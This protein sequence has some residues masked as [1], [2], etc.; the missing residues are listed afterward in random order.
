MP[1][2][3]HTLRLGTRGSLLARTQSQ[4]VADALV[5]RHP[6]LRVELVVCRTTGDR[7]TDRPLHGA[8][9]KG[10]FVKELEEALLRGE[11][12][13]AV[14]SS[15]DV[16]VTMPLVDQSD[17]LLAAFP[18]REDPRDV[19][20]CRTTK[21]I[22]GLPAHAKVGT[23]SLRRKAQLLSLRP[24][25]R[26]EL[27]RGNIDTR[28]NKC[29]K[30]SEYDA[31]IL[32]MSGLKRA[33]LFDE[34]T[35]TPLSVDEMVPA[36]GQGAL[37]LQCRRSDGTTQL[38]LSSLHDAATATCVGLERSLVTA[39]EGDC[40]SPIGALATVAG[41]SVTLRAAVAAVGGLPPLV[42]A[43]AR[44]DAPAAA[45]ADVLDQLNRQNVRPLLHPAARPA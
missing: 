20:V 9:G 27:L 7:I 34:R 3:A 26:V 21:G 28:V 42:M 11:V 43:S 39:L 38:L 37:A 44:G 25:L 5:A 19:L 15:K 22:A 17:L 16:P 32:A 36:A 1:T 41:G 10:L 23:G 35:M 4:L 8:G 12:D 30:T 45:L 40:A 14:H 13:F 33:A 31:V 2:T 24:D 18:P 6:G 29:L